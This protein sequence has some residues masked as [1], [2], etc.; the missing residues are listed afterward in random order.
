[1]PLIFNLMLFASWTLADFTEFHYSTAEDSYSTVLSLS[2]A[3]AL[4]L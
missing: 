4:H 2:F 1:M 3:T